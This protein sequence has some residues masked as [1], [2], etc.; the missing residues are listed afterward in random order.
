MRQH[1]FKLVVREGSTEVGGEHSAFRNLPWFAQPLG[2]SARSG[3]C[4]EGHDVITI[5][6]NI[7]V[8]SIQLLFHYIKKVIKQMTST[9]DNF[10]YFLINSMIH[11]C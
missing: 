5:I 11:L 3:T 9:A 2:G 4:L 7:G 10:D 1:S 8:Y 6:V